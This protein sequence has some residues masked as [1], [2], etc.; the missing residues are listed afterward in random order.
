MAHNQEMIVKNKEKWGDQVRI[1]GISID[2]TVE[3]VKAHVETNKW[4]DVEHFHRAS[5]SADNDYGVNGV[6]HVVLINMEGNIVFVGHPSSTN[7]EQNINDLLEGKDIRKQKEESEEKKDDGDKEKEKDAESALAEEAKL[8]ERI[9]TTV[10]ANKDLFSQ[11]LEGVIVTVLKMEH[12]VE[13]DTTQVTGRLVIRQEAE[14]EVAAKVK[15]LLTPITEEFKEIFNP[16][17][18]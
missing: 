13:K 11:S 12:N 10:E 6:P 16:D 7:L 5:S 8:K 17:I 18:D 4:T 9:I 15:E 14:K 3:A 1:I 2:K